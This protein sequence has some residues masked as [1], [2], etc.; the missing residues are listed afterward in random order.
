VKLLINIAF[1]FLIDGFTLFINA[2]SR[3]YKSVAVKLIYCFSKKYKCKNL[4]GVVD[5]D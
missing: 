5:E 4:G 2:L 3:V 1:F